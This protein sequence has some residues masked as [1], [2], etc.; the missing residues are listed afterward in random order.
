MCEAPKVALTLL[1]SLLVGCSSTSFE[2]VKL[3]PDMLDVA[4]RSEHDLRNPNWGYAPLETMATVKGG[5]GQSRPQAWGTL[6]DYLVHNGL[7][8]EMV[9]GD[10]MM[11]RL[12]RK[13]HFNTGSSQVSSDSFFWLER[14]AN[15]LAEQ[16]GIDVVIGGHTDN[17]G[18][19]GF[20]DHLSDRRAQQ[21]KQALINQQVPRQMIYT[22]GYSQ[23]APA[24][25][26]IDQYGQACNR[27]VELTL[28]VA[29]SK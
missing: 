10:Y 24:C 21:V 9:P 18:T 17:T 3:M 8:Y 6:E 29:N 22:R 12:K 27:R 2:D 11:I 5:N 23:H 16:N 13:I 28:L 15:F 19:L 25:S 7:D 14:L 26:N 1:T 20:N 4:P